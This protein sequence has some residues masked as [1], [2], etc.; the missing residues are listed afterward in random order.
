MAAV[1]QLQEVL[2]QSTVSWSFASQV[3]VS[4]VASTSCHSISSN[5]LELDFQTAAT[6]T[7]IAAA[8]GSVAIDGLVRSI[9]PFWH[10]QGSS[11]EVAGLASGRPRRL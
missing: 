3:Q 5:V 2:P 8:F 7:A 6:I 1:T 9:A 4:V 10:C 11:A